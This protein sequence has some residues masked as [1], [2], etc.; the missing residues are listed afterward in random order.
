MISIY[1]SE[2]RIQ[3][4][5][6]IKLSHREDGKE[7]ALTI[8]VVQILRFL[9]YLLNWFSQCNNLIYKNKALF[10][11]GGVSNNDAG[12]VLV[13]NTSGLLIPSYDLDHSPRIYDGRIDI[14]CYE[15]LVLELYNCETINEDIKVYFSATENILNI[16]SGIDSKKILDIQVFD[17]KGTNYNVTGISGIDQNKMQ[18]YIPGLKSGFYILRFLTLNGKICRKFVL[19]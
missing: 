18:L 6:A 12:P 16:I 19:N 7:S 1:F 4:D 9:H 14:G 15:S 17:V 13:N 10:F 3:Q 11:G 5:L 8:P 2:Y